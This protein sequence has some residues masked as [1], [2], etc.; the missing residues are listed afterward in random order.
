MQEPISQPVRVVEKAPGKVER[1]VTKARELTQKGEEWFKN[2]W[3][4]V[5]GKKPTEVRQVL[6]DIE[7]A[8]ETVLL[9]DEIEKPNQKV[10][11][12]PEEQI[13]SKPIKSVIES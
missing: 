13:F 4:K 2:K 10:E 7:G 11:G 5:T 6:K 12:T 9:T 3:E 8:D 1:V